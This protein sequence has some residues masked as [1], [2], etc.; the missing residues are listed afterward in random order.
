MV[1]AAR[2]FLTEGVTP[3]VEQAAQRAGVSRTTAYRYFANQ[4]AL[5]IAS[6]PELAATSLLD[7]DAPADPVDRL[8]VVTENIARQ[9]L[10]HEPELRSMLRLSLEPD[11]TPERLPLR[12]G[13]AL[14][15]I[16]D[17]LSPLRQRIPEAELR[18]LALAIRAT[19][20]IE[21]LVWL[22]DVGGL[23]TEQACDVMRSSARA[24]LQA[25]LTEAR[26]A[27]GAVT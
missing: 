23:S 12:R 21:P 10:E 6:Y 24:V 13:R 5:L 15:W 7:G 26:D 3:T 17:A 9:I 22:T 18:R 25:K 19:I 27:E 14:G 1:A 8:D 4:R 16:E 11:V 2:E 20:G